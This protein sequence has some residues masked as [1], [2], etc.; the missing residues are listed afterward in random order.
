METIPQMLE[1][2]NA[3]VRFA[4]RMAAIRTTSLII[5]V[6][7]AGLIMAAIGAKAIANLA[8]QNSRIDAGDFSQPGE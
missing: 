4:R 5:F 7:T 6:S 1:R 3:E 2:R 8:E